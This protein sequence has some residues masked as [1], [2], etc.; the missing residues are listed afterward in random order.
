MAITKGT[1]TPFAAPAAPS[2]TT[3]ATSSFDSSGAGLLVSGAIFEGADTTVVF[4]DNKGNTWQTAIVNLASNEFSVRCAMGWCVPTTVG[5]G[6]VIT[7]TLGAARTNR[8]IDALNVNGNFSAADALITS[9]NLD[10]SGT[11]VDAGTLVTTTAA[12]LCQVVGDNAG[13]TFT[14]GPGGWVKDSTTAG[15]HFQSRVEAAGGTFDPA[16]TL[17][18][19]Y[20]W[21]SVAMAFKETAVAAIGKT[22]RRFPNKGALR[23]NYGARTIGFRQG[24]A[25]VASTTNLDISTPGSITLAGQ[26]V[27]MGVG[28]A[29]S[30]QGSITLAGQSVTMGLGVAPGAGAITIAGQSVT[31]NLGLAVSTQ[32]SISINGQAIA[33]AQITALAID[34]AGSITLAGQSVAMALGL[35]PSSGS[36]TIAGQA[37][38]LAASG[39]QAMAIDV[40]GS[41]SILGQDVALFNSTPVDVGIG[42]GGGGGLGGKWEEKSTALRTVRRRKRKELEEALPEI[43]LPPPAIVEP[44]SIIPSELADLS[45]ALTVAPVADWADRLLSDQRL[46]QSIGDDARKLADAER[47]EQ[48]AIL[49]LMILLDE[50]ET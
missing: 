16:G 13:Q 46:R 43:E 3:I 47:E 26:S 31:S 9:A 29:L 27:T 45:Q 32:G 8:R 5:S 30:T 10:G 24:I 37:V 44:V 36:I 23:Q 19:G 28:V 42:G 40:P 14:Q 17:G 41:I 22:L 18:A 34:T 1:Y 38:T 6:H 48:E 15:S 2:T 12:I 50:D 21:S 20:D 7:G 49:A 11:A 33:L 39:S 35:A 25:Q 4:S